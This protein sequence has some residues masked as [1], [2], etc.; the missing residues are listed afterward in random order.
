MMSNLPWYVTAYHRLMTPSW[1]ADMARMSKAIWE[2]ELQV[3]KSV[4]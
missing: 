3:R 1:S 4:K 2:G